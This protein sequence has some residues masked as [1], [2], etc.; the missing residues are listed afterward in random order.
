MAHNKKIVL[1]GRKGCHYCDGLKEYF[2]KEGYVYS[3]VDVEGNDYLRDILELKYGIRHVPVI[4]IG[5]DNAFEALTDFE[6]I[7]RQDYTHIEALL[8]KGS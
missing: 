6:P 1:W 8:A 2:E 3:S 5:V 4:E 7:S